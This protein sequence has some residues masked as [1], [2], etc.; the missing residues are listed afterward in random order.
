MNDNIQHIFS[1]SG[2]PDHEQLL[3]YFRDELTGEE[4]HRIESHLLDCPMCTDELEGLSMMKDPGKLDEIMEEIRS[5]VAEKRTRVVRMNYRVVALAAAAVFVLAIGTVLTVRLITGE[6]AD[7]LKSPSYDGIARSPEIMQAPSPT[8]S[9][10]PV[11]EGS[12]AKVKPAGKPISSEGKSEQSVPENTTGAAA[13]LVMTDSESKSRTDTV[14]ASAVQPS[15]TNAV[16]E[17]TVP[18][19]ES[20]EEK[21][22]L[23]KEA[24]RKN[25]SDAGG[26]QAQAPEPAKD[27]MEFYKSG[28]YKKA[29]ALFEEELKKKPDDSKIRYYSAFCYFNLKKLTKASAMLERILA[30]PGDE[31][32]PAARTLSDK[33]RVAAD[34]IREQDS[35]R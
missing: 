13:S 5:G 1:E 9:T 18:A 31:Y 25:A 11:P 21:Q 3:A 27:A 26:I 20:R 15:L 17:M 6:H 2:C 32:Y 19:S 34:S 12:K 8:S 23:S 14:P 35:I 7:M 24:L 22:D 10:Q 28:N 30:D 4:K 29:A 33:I 16:S